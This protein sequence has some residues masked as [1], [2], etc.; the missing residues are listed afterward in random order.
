MAEPSSA[1]TVILLAA[2]PAGAQPL[3]KANARFQ[4][5]SPSPIPEQAG[6]RTM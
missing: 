6:Q 1:S 4:P 3:R 2:A 5:V